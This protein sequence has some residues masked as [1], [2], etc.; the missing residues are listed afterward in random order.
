MQIGTPAVSLKV[1]KAVIAN[2]EQMKAKLNT[3]AISD[4]TKNDLLSTAFMQVRGVTA[5][6]TVFLS[7]TAASMSVLTIRTTSISNGKL[8][9]EFRDLKSEVTVTATREIKTQDCD[10]DFFGGGGCTTRTRHENR[11]ITAEEGQRV[12][13]ALRES[14]IHSPIAIAEGI[15]FSLPNTASGQQFKKHQELR[16]R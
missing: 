15:A 16:R 12:M 6:W 10:D 3:Y 7:P 14:I 2:M 1:D 8:D 4:R 11:G 13:H 5:E 9:V